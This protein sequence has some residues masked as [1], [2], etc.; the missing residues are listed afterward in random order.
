MKK[1]GAI[2]IALL[3]VGPAAAAGLTRFKDWADS[4]QAYF[5]SKAEKEQWASITSDEAAEKFIAD[6]LAARGKGFAAA[7]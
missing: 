1:T 6:Y 4:P 5:L 3:L 7:L 2:A